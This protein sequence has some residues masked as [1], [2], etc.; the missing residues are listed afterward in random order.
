MQLIMAVVVML[1]AVTGL[2]SNIKRGEAERNMMNVMRKQEHALKAQ[3]GALKAQQEVI[4]RLL[5]Q[6]G[7][8]D[9]RAVA[10]AWK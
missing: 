6:K 5:A 10:V 8:G 4:S 7:C 2:I 3:Q 9:D 1:M